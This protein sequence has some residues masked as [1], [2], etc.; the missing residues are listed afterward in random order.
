M[1]SCELLSDV[2]RADIYEARIVINEY[3]STIYTKE[4]DTST[5]SGHYTSRKNL[6]E[7]ANDIK[8][9]SIKNGYILG[10]S[11]NRDLKYYCDVVFIAPS[12]AYSC[13]VV[14][15]SLS[16]TEY[17]AIFDAGLWIWEQKNEQQTNSM[18]DEIDD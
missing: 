7:V 5:T 6:Y 4:K 2:Y 18:K 15:A 17:Q 1:I 16:D 12:E 11:A 13:Y 10:S 9:W 8:Q 14:Y 3:E